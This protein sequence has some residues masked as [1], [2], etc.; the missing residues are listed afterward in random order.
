MK[1]NIFLYSVGI[2]AIVGVILCFFIGYPTNNTLP[3]HTQKQT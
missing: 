2:I 1:D 3:M